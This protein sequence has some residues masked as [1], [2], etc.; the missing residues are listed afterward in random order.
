MNRILSIILLASLGALVLLAAFQKQHWDTDIFWALK[1]GELI[2]NTF[3]VP[4]ADPFSYTFGAQPWVDFTWGFQVLAHLFYSGLGDW[5]GLF[6][7]QSVLTGLTFVFLYVNLS[8]SAPGKK[9]LVLSGLF[10]VYAASHTRF[11]IRPHLFEYFFVSLYLMLFTLYEKKG[12]PVFIYALLP[13]QVL[14]VNVHSSAVLGIFIAGAYALGG[15]IDELREKGINT[16]TAF[17]PGILHKVAAAIGVPLAGLLNPY[18]LKLVIFP[19]IHQG[20]DN[21]DALRHIGEW[22]APKLNEL[23]F[24]FYPFPL[25]RF[26]FALLSVGVLAGFLLNLR[27][28][29]LKDLLLAGAGIY[30][31]TSHNRWIALFAYFSAPVAAA[32]ISEWMER[33]RANWNANLSALVFFLLAVLSYDYARNWKQLGLGLKSAIYPESTV[34]FMKKNAI[35]GNMYNEYVFGGYLIFNHPEA[36]VFI[37]GR[38]PTVYSPY[39][40]WTS[41]LVDTT[42]TWKRLVEEYG[43]EVALVKLNVPFCEKL[44]KS[45]EWT[46]VSFDDVAALYLKDNGAYGAVVTGSGLK[47]VNPC[48]VN[49]KYKLPK[50]NEKL[51]AMRE[52]LKRAIGQEGQKK[53]ARPHRLLGLVDLELGEAHYAEAAAEFEKAL[54]ISE[55]PYILYDLGVALGKLKRHEEAVEAFER[56]LEMDKGFKDGYLGAGLASFDLKDYKKAIK[57]LNTYAELA[58]DTAEQ[59]AFKTLGMSYFETGRFDHASAYLKRAAYLTDDIKELGSISYYTANALSEAGRYREAAAYYSKALEANPEYF[60]VL[61]ELSEDFRRKGNLERARAIK[62]VIEGLGNTT[63]H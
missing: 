31:A 7:L 59:I 8:L 9:W 2:V 10:L 36:R 22:L 60:G 39:F 17:S 30:M 5:T 48:S 32:N 20:V 34:E 51:L 3:E 47:E 15:V 27:R 25:D 14:W 58:D 33:R 44:H 56:A 45:G 11:F 12:S 63:L 16:S 62:T 49:S 21:R 26:A 50:E 6:I 13:L 1:T 42:D 43:I 55:D 54:S 37:D 35:T 19:F 23:F 38:T 46:A 4:K 61:N 18:G 28:I 41:R 52:E 40:F 57:N 29:R 53:A 24:Y